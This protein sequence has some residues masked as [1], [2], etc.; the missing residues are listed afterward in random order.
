M[1]LRV[2]PARITLVTQPAA[3]GAVQPSDALVQQLLFKTMISLLEYYTAKVSFALCR[4]IGQTYG[5]R[6]HVSS[7]VMIYSWFVFAFIALR[8]H[9][10]DTFL[11]FFCP[12]VV[13]VVLPGRWEKMQQ[14]WAQEGLPGSAL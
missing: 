2:V 1:T 5:L 11:T 9:K 4:G 13:L 14:H 8:V 12:F 7:G 6:E 10:Q 3:Q